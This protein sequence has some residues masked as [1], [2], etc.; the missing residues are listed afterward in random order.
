MTTA[1]MTAP[2]GIAIGP[3]RAAAY[4]RLL[5]AAVAVVNDYSTPVTPAV[6]TLDLA[7]DQFRATSRA[8]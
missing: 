4:D 6:H 5:A 7:V 1:T 3:D 8:V 2:A